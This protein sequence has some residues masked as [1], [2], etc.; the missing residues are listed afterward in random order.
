MTEETITPGCSLAKVTT[1][2]SIAFLVEEDKLAWDTRVKDILPDFEIRDDVIRNH[3]TVADLLCHRTGM[4]WGD[5]YYISTENN[6][7]IPG[8][9]GMEY[10]GNREPV[11]PFPG[12]I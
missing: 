5:N 4:S 11:L 12:L 2:A 7:I 3:I 1:A 6:Y 9:D 10:M 8:K